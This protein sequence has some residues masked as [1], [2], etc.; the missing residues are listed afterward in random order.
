MDSI[1][2][3]IHWNE[4]SELKLFDRD[5]ICVTHNGRII[6]FKARKVERDWEWLFEKY[7]IKYWAF[8]RDVLATII[9]ESFV[10]KKYE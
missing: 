2:S 5:I 10:S 7:N 9:Q 4:P 6:T 8:L 3:I 1:T